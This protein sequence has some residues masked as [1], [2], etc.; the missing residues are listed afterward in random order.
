[1][2]F[3]CL[4]IALTAAASAAPVS[5]TTALERRQQEF[6]VEIGPLDECAAGYAICD[7]T[8]ESTICCPFDNTCFV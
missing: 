2:R 5:N 6:C 1:M 4:I 3:L 8:D 7:Q